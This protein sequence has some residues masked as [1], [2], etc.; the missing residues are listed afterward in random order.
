MEAVATHCSAINAANA[1]RVQ[2]TSSCT[3][4]QDGSCNRTAETSSCQSGQHTSLS[5]ISACSGLMLCFR[6]SNTRSSDALFARN[7]ERAQFIVF[8]ANLIACLKAHLRC[9]LLHCNFASNEW[10]HAGPDTCAYSRSSQLHACQLTCSGR[11][12][13]RCA[14]AHATIWYHA[15]IHI[16]TRVLR[17]R[18]TSGHLLAYVAWCTFVTFACVA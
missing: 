11:C 10:R 7:L 15:S 6:C 4:S 14:K 2:D 8:C 12:T 9:F 13:G 3:K 1:V 16:R 5:D 18:S 17:A